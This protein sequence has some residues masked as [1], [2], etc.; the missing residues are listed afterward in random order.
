MGSRAAGAASMIVIPLAVAILGNFLAIRWADRRGGEGRSGRSSPRAPGTPPGAPNQQ[1]I[2]GPATG[3]SQVIDQ[4]RHHSSVTNNFGGPPG[5]SE[6]DATEEFVGQLAV[7]AVA[8][9]CVAAAF[10]WVWPWIPLVTTTTGAAFVGLA[11]GV[12]GWMERHSPLGTSAARRLALRATVTVLAVQVIVALAPLAPQPRFQTLGGVLEHA[13]R[14]GLGTT[15]TWF[16]STYGWG[17]TVSVALQAFGLAALVAVFAL[18]AW[19][20]VRQ[21]AA[22]LSS[23][24]ARSR[25][26]ARIGDSAETRSLDQR[27]GAVL[28]W[29][30]AVALA[31]GAGGVVGR[32]I[33]GHST[34]ASASS[35]PA[36]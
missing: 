5:A 30:L 23:G 14:D 2:V 13:P 28:A 22:V 6:D 9:V 21:M 15:S 25:L 26:A 10:V 32:A 33:Q 12:V 19:S 1:V 34:S 17:P 3:N 35:V 18:S 7:C 24:G 4:S 31:L 29:S 16:I 27:A 20:L 11:W 8:V 36:R